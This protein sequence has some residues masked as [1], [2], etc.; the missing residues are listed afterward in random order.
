MIWLLTLSSVVLVSIISFIG[1]L[2]FHWKEEEMKPFLIILVSFSAGALLGDA[3]IHLLPE[4]ISESGFSTQIALMI[5]SGI[6]IFFILEKFICWRHCH[7]P[8]EHGYIK[9]FA[10]MNLV[11]DGLHNLIDGMIV[12]GSYLISIQVGIATT[13]AVVLHEIPQ[14]ISDF[15]VLL[16]G[17]LPKQKAILMNFL[18]AATAIVGAAF[19]LTLRLDPGA[20]AGFLAPFTIGG[21]LYIAGADLIPEL[22]KTTNP[23]GSLAQFFSLIAGIAVMMSLLLLE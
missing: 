13:I 16:H 17:G 21:F 23:L 15:A 6:L 22:H 7:S 10:V 19:I 2:A 5:L 1:I 8:V 11:G 12:A 9:P 14:E 20:I 3:F 18:S 4:T